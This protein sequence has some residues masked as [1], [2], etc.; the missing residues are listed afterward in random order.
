GKR[1]L[2]QVVM[3]PKPNGTSAAMGKTT[4]VVISKIRRS[5]IRRFLAILSDG[6]AIFYVLSGANLFLIRRRSN[7]EI[8]FTNYLWV[9]SNLSADN[10]T[11]VKVQM[12]TDY[13][14]QEE[15]TNYEPLESH[16][17]HDYHA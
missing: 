3:N 1:V 16:S 17:G 11:N 4:A 9:G 2:F 12:I 6:K 15:K 10:G 13:R 5:L 8:L 7:S 14:Y